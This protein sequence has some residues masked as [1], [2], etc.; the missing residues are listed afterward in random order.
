MRRGGE[1]MKQAHVD[2]PWYTRV[3]RCIACGQL[4]SVGELPGLACPHC[5]HKTYFT[6]GTGS[7]K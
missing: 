1:F 5:G 6:C 4:S 3:L 2:F 7:N